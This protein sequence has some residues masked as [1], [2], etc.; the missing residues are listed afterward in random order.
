N[1]IPVLAET[2]A[3]C[4][5]VTVINQDVMKC[6]LA[7]LIEREFTSQGLRV[8]VAANLPYYIT[9]PILMKLVESRIPFDTITVMI[10]KEVAVRLCAPAGD[11]KYGAIT[12]SLS[13]YGKVERLFTVPAGCFVPAPKVDSAV[14]RIHLYRE[15]PVSVAREEMLFR[16]IRGAFAQRRKTLANSLTTEFS[17]LGRDAIAAA[18]AECGLDAS[19][20]GERLTLAD[21]AR[22]ADILNE[23]L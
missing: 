21:F 8:S 12:A 15:P 14:V 20:R 2:L 4:P 19:I 16:V 7:E 1:L 9:T 23:K 10:Q 3:D 22:L 11:S 18:I 17:S 13:Y 6:D 5:N